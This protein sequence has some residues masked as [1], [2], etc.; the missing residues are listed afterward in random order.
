MNIH[1]VYQT[2]LIIALLPAHSISA[3]RLD[4]RNISYVIPAAPTE[5]RN[6]V[7]SFIEVMLDAP[8]ILPLIQLGEVIIDNPLIIRQYPLILIGLATFS[9]EEYITQSFGDLLYVEPS[10]IPVL[11]LTEN[12]MR[13]GMHVLNFSRP[14]RYGLVLD[15]ITSRSKKTQNNTLEHAPLEPYTHCGNYHL[16]HTACARRLL[17]N[18]CPLCRNE[19]M[20][21]SSLLDILKNAPRDL[22]ETCMICLEENRI[23]GKNARELLKQLITSKKKQKKAL[24]KLNGILRASHHQ[25]ITSNELLHCYHR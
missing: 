11:P 18:I 1:T 3:D 7:P 9:I 25:D 4:Y 21:S 6:R 12:I 2:L 5:I 17:T 10:M 19:N 13:L 20:V 24:K 8:R 22:D 23:N 14:L 16:L 15:Y